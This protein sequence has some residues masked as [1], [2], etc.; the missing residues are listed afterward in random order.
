M[1]LETC[2]TCGLVLVPSMN[3]EACDETHRL[4]KDWNELRDFEREL[5]APIEAEYRAA[6]GPMQH[7][8][9]VALADTE[10]EYGARVRQAKADLY[11][12]QRR[13]REVT[14]DLRK[15]RDATVRAAESEYE[16]TRAPWGV[17]RRRK[18]K[19]VDDWHRAEAGR[20][21]DEARAKAA[22]EKQA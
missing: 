9:K 10:R 16:G 4:P 5:R 17:E 14:T 7:R 20:L 2:S 11:V 15:W 6:V 1:P 13:F 19:P 21:M 12:A 8:L 18:M 3:Q 22:Q